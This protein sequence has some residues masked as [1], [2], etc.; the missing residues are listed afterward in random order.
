MFIDNNFD[1]LLNLTFLVN[2][3]RIVFA[4][5]VEKTVINFS[6]SKNF[7]KKLVV[8]DIFEEK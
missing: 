6:V 7:S 2:L 4:T 8:L 3:L 1:K 5:G